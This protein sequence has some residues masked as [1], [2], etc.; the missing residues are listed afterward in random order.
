MKFA[1]RVARAANNGLDD[2]FN[3]DAATMT[4]FAGGYP[5]PAVFPKQALQTA[6]SATTVSPNAL[7]YADAAGYAPLRAQL[8]EGLTQDGIPTQAADLLLTQG[9]QQGIDL[10]ARLLIDPGDGL[11]VEGPTY[12]G[13]LAAFDAYEPTYYE[14][15][16][17]ADG[18]DLHA[19]QKVLMTHQVKLIYTIP[20][21]QNPTGA[22]MSVAKRKA[23]VALAAQY[24]V[25]ILEDGPYRQLRYRGESLPPLK[26]FD[27]TGH[28]IFIGSMSKILAPSLRLGYLTAPQ[29][30]LKALTALRGGSDVESSNLIMKSV[31]QYLADND[32]SAHLT[33]LRQYYSKKATA[34]MAALD[35]A[36]PAGFSYHHVDGGFFLWLTGPAD[37]DMAA[38]QQ[39]H[40]G[41]DA[42]VSVVPS[43]NLFPSHQVTNAARLTFAAPAL[44]DIQPGIA[45]LCASLATA[46]T[47]VPTAAQR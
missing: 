4:S 45:R 43:T 2:L 40:L 42:R 47:A 9:A 33:A 23:L 22:V 14:V 24:D 44:A 16:V 25:M 26:H 38:W 19:L 5:D 28:V 41:P 39:A 30:I 36:L 10:T 31:S 8:A 27:T 17:E 11:V 15:P 18:M 46:T 13:A 37:F 35:E 3:D 29:P 6:F 32:F 7:Q 1:R 34:M 20:D 12:L 21:F